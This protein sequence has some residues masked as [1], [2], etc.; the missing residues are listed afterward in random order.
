MYGEIP[1]GLMF[2]NFVGM[3]LLFIVIVMAI[4]WLVRGARCGDGRHFA[5]PW[6]PYRGGHGGHGR[7]GGRGGYQGH[8][9]HKRHGG[10]NGRGAHGG[11]SHGRRGHGGRRHGGGGTHRA[12]GEGRG[13]R[14]DALTLARV[15]LARSEISVDE[16]NAIRAA[17]EA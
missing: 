3:V 13:R 9:G 8:G 17:L 10:H 11:R 16:Y 6:G 12:H 1:I 7:H 15:R 14:D 2:L 4:K 5:G